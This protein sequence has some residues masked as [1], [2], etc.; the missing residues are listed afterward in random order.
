MSDQGILYVPWS[1]SNKSEKRKTNTN[2]AETAHTGKNNVRVL[3][4]V[5]KKNVE[6][7]NP[8]RCGPV[9]IFF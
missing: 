2:G 9:K 4:L 3:A 5:L 7:K 6:K 8:P 1:K